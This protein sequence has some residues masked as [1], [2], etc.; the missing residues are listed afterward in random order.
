MDEKNNATIFNGT[1]NIL[2][3]HGP[4]KGQFSIT[5]NDKAK[6]Y[7]SFVGNGFPKLIPGDGGFL[8]GALLICDARGYDKYARRIMLTKTGRINADLATAI[9]STPDAC[10]SS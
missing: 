5:G 1:L 10:P 6:K 8:G 9:G 2:R 7:I 3:V 4:V